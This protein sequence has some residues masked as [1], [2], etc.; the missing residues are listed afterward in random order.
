M[1]P[2]SDTTGSQTNGTAIDLDR[3]EQDLADVDIALGRLEDGTYWTCEV[4]GAEIPAE[5]LAE[6]PTLRR[7]V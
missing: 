1:G 3:I 2:V 7:A 5:K 4:T 6:N